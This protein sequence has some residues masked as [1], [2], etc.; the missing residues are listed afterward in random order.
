MSKKE[1]PF[2]TKFNQ[3]SEELQKVAKE[4]EWQNSKVEEAQNILEEKEQYSKEAEP[5]N[6]KMVKGKIYTDKI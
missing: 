3:V 1:N 4:G 2:N 5:Q 6:R